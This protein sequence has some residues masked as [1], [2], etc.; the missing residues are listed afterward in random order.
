MRRVPQK[1]QFWDALRIAGGMFNA[2]YWALSSPFVGGTE[3]VGCGPG[4][5]VCSLSDYIMQHANAAVVNLDGNHGGVQIVHG[6]ASPT[7][8]F[9]G[10]VD[11][12]TI[13]KNMNNSNSTITYDFQA[14]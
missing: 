12:F 2:C 4:T 14:P 8:M 5:N 6:F 1:W 3:T 11:A 13:G 9:N 10:W 7:D